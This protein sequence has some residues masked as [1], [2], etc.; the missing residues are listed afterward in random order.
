MATTTKFSSAQ[1]DDANY[2]SKPPLIRQD[3]SKSKGRCKVEPKIRVVF[4]PQ[5]KAYIASLVTITRTLL[6][7]YNVLFAE[8]DGSQSSS[9]I[10]AFEDTW[11]KSDKSRLRQ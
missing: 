7:R 9:Q 5:E 6:L 1:Q 4:L 10:H 8:K 3:E 2:I 11:E